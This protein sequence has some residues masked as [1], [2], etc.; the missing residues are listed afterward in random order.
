VFR[1]RI[2]APSLPGPFFIVFKR[3]AT[4]LQPI[5]RNETVLA[6]SCVGLGFSKADAVRMRFTAPARARQ[7]FLACSYRIRVV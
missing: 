6:P 7:F 5:A 1:A 2:F 3:L 4:A